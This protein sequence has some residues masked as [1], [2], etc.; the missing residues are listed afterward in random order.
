MMLSHSPNKLPEPSEERIHT[1]IKNHN[2]FTLTEALV[3]GIILAIL[4]GGLLAILQLNATET[5]EGVLS[6]RLQMKYEN[7]VEQFSRDARF[8][9]LILAT[10]EDPNLFTT[11]DTDLSPVYEIIM[12]DKLNIFYASYK[13]SGGSGGGTLQEDKGSG[14]VDYISGDSHVTLAAGSYF[15]LFA[16]RGY[17]EANLDVE[18][19][20][21]NKSSTLVS[22]A[23]FIRCRN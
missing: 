1:M 19:S 8:S 6:S 4:A 16:Y 22:N 10:G 2:G 15:K 12:Y 5:S 23:I 13:I 21:K 20:Y 9:K 7:I 17:S 11:Y 3:T 14:Y 18:S